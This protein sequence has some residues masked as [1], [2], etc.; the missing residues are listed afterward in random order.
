MSAF[1]EYFTCAK[2][3]IGANNES[4]QGKEA[5]FECLDA[6]WIVM[7]QLSCPYK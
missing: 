2:E 5:I 4:L 1:I 3:S 6:H 7:D